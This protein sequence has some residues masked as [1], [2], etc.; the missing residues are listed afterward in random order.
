V[1]R[2]KLNSL[3]TQFSVAVQD[4][5]WAEA[6]E[7]GEEIMRDFPNTKIAEEVRE[8]MD[9]MRRRATSGQK[10]ES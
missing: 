2:E 5:K 6:I 3:R 7:V 9:T 10:V 4:H 1:I 8:R